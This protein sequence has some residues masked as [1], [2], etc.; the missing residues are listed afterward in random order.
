MLA[1]ETK[2]LTKKYKSKTV[3]DGLNLTVDEGELFALLGVNGAGKT[4]TIRMLTC[5]AKPSGGECSV[6]GHNCVSDSAAVKELVG[7]SPQD[8]AV[9][10][11]LTVRENLSLMCGI[12][13]FSPDKAK[14]RI[15]EMI[16]LFNIHD[17]ANSRAKT[18]SGGWKRKLSIALALISE[19]KLLF[20]DEPT[21]GLDVIARRELWK[22]IRELKSRVTIV[23]TTHYMEEAES[24]ADR[25][26]VMI[27]GHLAALGTLS[28]LEQQTGESGLENVFVKITDNFGKG[29]S[30]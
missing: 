24:L 5:L 23:L 20:L 15:N 19:P 11:N 22:V 1:I 27:S 7:I 21:L 3:V 4:T 16:E 26:A 14:S 6:C 25:I 18:L 8:T 29:E 13:G 28:E 30:K 2:G 17:V 9:A 10:E 12:Y